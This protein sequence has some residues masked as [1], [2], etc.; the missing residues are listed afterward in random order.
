MTNRAIC[1]TAA[2]YHYDD[3][4]KVASTC[5]NLDKEEHTKLYLLLK[6]YEFLFDGTLGIWNTYPVDILLKEY[7]IPYN[8]R[9]F[10][11]PRVYKTLF[12]ENIEQ[13]S[14]L[15]VLCICNGS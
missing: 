9:P 13:L 3:L 5:T 6:K 10:P 1:T 12:R 2:D 4:A 7:V 15:E 14:K 11:A 8:A